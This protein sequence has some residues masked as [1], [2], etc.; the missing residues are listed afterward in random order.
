[1][2]NRFFLGPLALLAPSTMEN[3]EVGNEELTIANDEGRIFVV[4]GLCP[5]AGA[6]MCEG[7]LEKGTI[8]C[9]W[10]SGKFDLETGKVLATPPLRA[11]RTYKVVHEA[12]GYWIYPASA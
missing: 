11:L 10:H 8:T 2:E 4:E 5:H 3:I 9:P 1:M 12:D 7:T 6:P